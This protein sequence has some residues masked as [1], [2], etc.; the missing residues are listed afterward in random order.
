MSLVIALDANIIVTLLLAIIQ[1][2][3]GTST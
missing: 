3:S 2:I 1:D